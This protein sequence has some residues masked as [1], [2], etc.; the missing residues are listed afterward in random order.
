MHLSSIRH[1]LKL[2]RRCLHVFKFFR[3]SIWKRSLSYKTASLLSQLSSPCKSL[4]KS[5]ELPYNSFSQRFHHNL[6]LLVIL[7]RVSGLS[8]TGA[9]EW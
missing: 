9:S 4:S 6:L 1:L 8:G 5:W 7:D 2:R 3:R